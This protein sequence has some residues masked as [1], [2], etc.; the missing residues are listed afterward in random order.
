MP[1]LSRFGL[2]RQLLSTFQALV[3]DPLGQIQV[4]PTEDR[5]L[6]Q[7]PA[8]LRHFLLDFLALEEFLMVAKGDGSRELMAAL[9]AFDVSSIRLSFHRIIISTMAGEHETARWQRRLPNNRLVGYARVSTEDQ[10]V[11][12]QLRALRRR[13][14]EPARLCLDTASGARAHKRLRI[15]DICHTLHLSRAPCYRYLTWREAQDG[16]SHRASRATS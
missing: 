8:I 7:P 13:G 12:W 10:D 3:S 5:I 11:A 4:V 1:P 9:A 16:Q 15:A 2:R 6:D 14:C